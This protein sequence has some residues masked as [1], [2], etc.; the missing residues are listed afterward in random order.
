MCKS[1]L[2]W[3]ILVLSLTLSINLRAAEDSALK[4]LTVQQLCAERDK[5][6]VWKELRQRWVFSMRELRSIERGTVR[7]GISEEALFCFMGEPVD[8]K[9]AGLNAQTEPLED[10]YYPGDGTPTLIVRVRHGLKETTVVDTFESFDAFD[11][12]Q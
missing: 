8:V 9:P 3:P 6:E 10:Y 7:S 12:E 2:S 5:P 11:S 4:D 1:G